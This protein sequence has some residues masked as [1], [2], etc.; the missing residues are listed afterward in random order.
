MRTHEGAIVPE[1]PE[2]E[3][4]R[5]QL[6]RWL[7]GRT[8]AAIALPDPSTIR[9]KPSTRPSDADPRGPEQL[10]TVVGQ[11]V[12]APIRHG[13]RL[14][15][16]IGDTAWIVHLGMTGRWL[17]R[18][19][20]A[21]A[22]RFA[23]L[24][25]ATDAGWAW[26]ADTRRFGCAVW[27]PQDALETELARGHGPDALLDPLDGEA[28]AARFATRQA[29]K[30]ALLDQTRIAGV[31]NIH[32]VEALFR[33]GIDPTTPARSLSPAAWAR[34]APAI[35]TQLQDALAI[36]DADEVVYMTD[37]QHVDNPFAVYGRADQP[38]VACATPIVQGR[39]GGRATFWCPGCQAHT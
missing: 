10:A 12:A 30:V 18:E 25:L 11:R 6:E 5:R 15:L 31:G 4:A 33:A 1:L 27:V 37:G 8:V 28:L 21:D 7:T 29:I 3:V 19:P 9:H 34:L 14:G 2:V 35:V 24:G 22:P 26:F 17:W 20:S 23:R 13:K 16:R 39:H 32:A 38:C 36:T